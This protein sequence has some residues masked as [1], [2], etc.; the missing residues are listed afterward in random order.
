MIAI[1][2]SESVA[3]PGQSLGSSFSKDEVD[4][5]LRKDVKDDHVHLRELLE[6]VHDQLQL[7]SADVSLLSIASA[8]DQ[9]RDQ[10][11]LHFTLK[12]SF[13]YLND[14][15]EI[16]PRL[17]RQAE[18]LR[19]EQFLLFLEICELADAAE[20]LVDFNGATKAPQ[21]ASLSAR[22]ET[23]A[24]ELR[25]HDGRERDLIYQALC[26]DIGVGD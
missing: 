21:I 22:Y 9:L 17:C 3:C 20:N 13:G 11:A 24:T 7:R 23:F 6:L 18:Q 4:E 1:Q 15:L 8:L 12:E 10:L 16:A 19:R 25:S 5:Q 26:D 2:Y 14:T